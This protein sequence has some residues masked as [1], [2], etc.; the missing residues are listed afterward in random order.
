MSAERILFAQKA[1]NPHHLARIPLADL[2]LNSTPYGAHSTA[3]DA[4]TMGLPILTLQG[5][6]FA[7]RFCSSVVAAAGLEDLICRTPEEYVRRAI[8]FGREPQTLVRY[9]E[10]LRLGRRVER[11][12]RHP[13]AGA[14]PRTI[15]LADAE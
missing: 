11:P 2:F 10:Q 7:S 15:V 1:A 8:A 9:R 4:L 14:S 12:S 6:S 3:A 13:G 5:R